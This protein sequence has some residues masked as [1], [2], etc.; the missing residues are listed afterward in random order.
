MLFKNLPRFTNSGSY[1]VNVSW[2]YLQSW[3]KLQQQARG[4]DLTPSFHR[5]HVWSLQQQSAYVEYIL[6]GGVSGR[7][8]YL[9]CPSWSNPVSGSSYDDFV[10]VDGLQRLSAVM[11][12]LNNEITAFCYGISD[13][14]DKLPSH[15][16]FVVHVNE[17]KT[18]AEV[19]QWYVELNASGTPHTVGELSRVRLLLSTLQKNE[20]RGV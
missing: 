10:C 5:G 17:L 19:L 3:V 14:T 9:N 18:E 4:L 8:I 20:N 7:D 1:S 16:E 12:F 11:S 2:E 15:A 6:S 13:F